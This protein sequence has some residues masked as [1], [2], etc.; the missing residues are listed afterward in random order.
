MTDHNSIKHTVR[1]HVRHFLV[2]CHIF[3]SVK[4]GH[5][6]HISHTTSIHFLHLIWITIQPYLPLTQNSNAQSSS[7]FFKYI[8]K[9]LAFRCCLFIAFCA[10]PCICHNA[11]C[12]LCSQN[13]QTWM[14]HDQTICCSQTNITPHNNSVC[15]Y[16]NEIKVG[17]RNCVRS[18]KTLP[19]HFAKGANLKGSN[20]IKNS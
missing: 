17:F 6:I 1:C 15:L 7:L 20:E 18:M 10:C 13:S 16:G 19:Q 5:T 3:K 9:L 12:D 14:E 11:A 8:C 2:L 4:P